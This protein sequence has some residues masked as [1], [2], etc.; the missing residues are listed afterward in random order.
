MKKIESLLYLRKYA[1]AFNEW[2]GPSPRLSTRV[3][4]LQTSKSHQNNS[5][6]LVT[7]C[8][9]WPAR[10]SNPRPRSRSDNNFSYHYANQPIWLQYDVGKFC[11]S[12]FEIA[13]RTVLAQF[14]HFTL[15]FSFKR[16]GLTPL[17][18]PQLDIIVLLCSGF[19]FA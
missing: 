18:A 13:A 4:Q 5:E 6:L 3:T 19:A 1:K 8:P 17:D 15:R 9:I 2:R 10:G 12:C 16:R 11:R 7:V 14:G